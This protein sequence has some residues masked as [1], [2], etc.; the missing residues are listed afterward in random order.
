LKKII[1]KIFIIS[2]IILL[3]VSCSTKKNTFLSRNINTLATKY[4]VLYNGKIAFDKEKKQIDDEFQDDF[5]QILSIEPLTIK[6]EKIALPKIGPPGSK[7]SAPAEVSKQGFKRA[8]EKAV[9]AIQRHSMDIG[10]KEKNSK[11]DDAYFLLAKSRY[12]DQRFIPA[13]ETFNYMIKKYPKSK[14]FNKVRIWEAKTLIRLGQ[15]EEA[16][17]SLDEYLTKTKDLPDNI[18]DNA[19]TALAMAYINMDS[20]QQVINHL[21]KALLYTKHNYNQ[22]TRNS[23]VLAQLYRQQNKI[24][25]S[26]FI[27]DR[28]TNYNKAPY[29]Y[30]IYAQIERA[31]NY[32]TDSNNGEDLLTSLKKLTKNRDNRPYLDGIFYQL[33]KINLA[34]NNTNEAIDY[35]KKSVSTLQAKDV[36]KSYAYEELGNIFFDKGSFQNAGSYYDSVLNIAK[37]K[38]VKRIRKLTRKRKSLDEVIKLEKIASVNDSILDL[39]AMSKDDQTKFFK[40][41]IKKL[42]KQA[43]IEKIINQNKNKTGFGGFGNIGSNNSSA[44]SKF[45]FYNTQ[46]VGFGQQEFQKIWGNRS[47]VDNWR[48]SS[49]EKGFEDNSEEIALNDQ[50]IDKS[51][52]FDVDYYLKKIPSDKNTIDS[53]S[54]FRNKAYYN[55]GLIYKEQFSKYQ[56]ATTR[57]EKLLNQQPKEKLILPTYYHLYK[58]YEKFD[59]VKSDFYKNKITSEYADSRY[60]QLI[61]DPRSIDVDDKNSPEEQYKKVYALYLDKDYK[62]TLN[63]SKEHIKRL[64]ETPIIPKF[65]LLKA[66]AIAKLEGKEPFIKALNFIVVNYANTIEGKRAIEILAFLKG[67]GKLPN[68]EEIIKKGKK[69]RNDIRKEKIKRKGNKNLPSREEM[70]EK[71]KGKKGGI[72]PPGGKG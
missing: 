3:I 42:K 47:L 59:Q 39:A 40:D 24:D 65:E 70:M 51:R 19:H 52:E 29:R 64:T 14:L 28:I 44:G 68:K 67:G 43:E 45:Y 2:Q 41:H 37:N 69:K 1:I 54:N 57:L 38:N 22:E 60:A 26:N 13:L 46:S 20:T 56:L 25:S 71:I 62:E 48:Y 12:Y 16:I 53:I 30:K 66:H 15:E 7:Q 31:K 63:L 32:N 33:G 34:N 50:K 4:N 11:I 10:S 8:E 5:W 49:T 35:L 61:N 72:T 6:E 58:S 36:Q 17:Y 18:L 55:L 27:F 9:K 21:N 23:F